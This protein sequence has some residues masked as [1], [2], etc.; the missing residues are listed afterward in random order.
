[1]FACISEFIKLR[2][3]ATT[4]ARGLMGASAYHAIMEDMRM[5]Q[6]YISWTACSQLLPA[7]PEPPDPEP[8]PDPSLTLV[9]GMTTLQCS[10]GRIRPTGQ[11]N[12]FLYAA[13]HQLTV[14]GCTKML[15]RCFR[16]PDAHTR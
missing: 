15:F 10:G 11:R 4:G 7:D 16:G 13:D 6:Q 1:M 12:S 8:D 5:R 9:H 3:T 2:P 14:R